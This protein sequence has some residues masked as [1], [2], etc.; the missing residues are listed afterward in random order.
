[1]TVSR[2]TK[3]QRWISLAAS[4]FASGLLLMI[5]GCGGP[6][7]CV[8]TGK[9]LVDNAPA[10]GVYV[11]FHT[12]GGTTERPD[13]GSAR[14][15]E[16]GSYSLVV[17]MPGDSVVTAFWPK[18]TVKDGETTEGPDLFGGLYRDPQQPVAKVAIHE[19]ENDVPPISLTRPKPGKSNGR[20]RR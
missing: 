1:M 18:V 8:V 14:S 17:S 10:E 19:G 4:P 20:D 5:V 9:V 7:S 6:S 2:P 16:D 13:A 11:I 12:V 3:L 15:V